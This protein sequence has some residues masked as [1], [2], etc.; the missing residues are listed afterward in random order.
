MPL[1]TEGRLGWYPLVSKRP[2]AS[3]YKLYVCLLFLMY[4]EEQF[5]EK[6]FLSY[7]T[8]CWMDLRDCVS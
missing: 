3:L 6:R 2:I 5:P 7:S 4:E 8:T 1:D